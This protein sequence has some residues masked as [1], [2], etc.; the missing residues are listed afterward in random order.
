MMI[1]VSFVTILYFVKKGE[2]TNDNLRRGIFSFISLI[3]DGS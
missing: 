3:I 2:L 1:D